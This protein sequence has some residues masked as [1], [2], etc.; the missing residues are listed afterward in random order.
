M[1]PKTLLVIVFFSILLAILSGVY[2]QDIASLF[3]KDWYM[4]ILIATTIISI[5]LFIIAAVIEFMI[6][7][8]EKITSRL[9]SVMLTIVLLI[10]VTVGLFISWRSLFVVAMSWG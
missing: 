6:L 5:C 1:K 10:T 4:V 7:I 9:F 3:P 8:S 2:A